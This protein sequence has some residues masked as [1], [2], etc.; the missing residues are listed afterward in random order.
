MCNEGTGMIHYARFLTE[1]D[2]EKEFKDKIEIGY[3][4]NV[5]GN[6]KSKF[7]NVE[8]SWKPPHCK[9]CSIFG[10]FD[11]KCMAKN[12]NDSGNI[13]AENEKVSTDS[14]KLVDKEGEGFY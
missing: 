14:E 8:Y 11:A 9:H 4:G 3:K 12:R 6:N 10:H 5:M 7:V 2:A 13:G 1:V